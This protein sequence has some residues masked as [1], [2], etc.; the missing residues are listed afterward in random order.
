MSGLTFLG[1]STDGFVATET[2]G[3]FSNANNLNTFDEMYKDV[4]TEYCAKD[5]N[6]MQDINT[7][8]KKKSMLAG[9][10]DRLLGELK[11]ECENMIAA[12]Q[13]DPNKEFG[14]HKTYYEMLSNMF[15]NCV[16]DFVKESTRVGNLLPIKAVDFPILIKQQLKLATKDIIQTEVTRTPIVKKHIEQTYIIDPKTNKRWKYPQAMYTDEFKEVYAAGMGLPI[17]ETAVELP[18]FDYDVVGGLTDAVP[19]NKEEFT[20][21][22]QVFAVIVGDEEI[23]LD[24]PMRINLSDNM[25]LGG[26]IDVTLA[27]GTEFKDLLSGSVDFVNKTVTLSSAKGEDGVTAVKFRG[28]LNN[29][30]NR[31]TVTFDYQREEREWKIDDG[32]K[33][34]AQYTL[35]QLEDHKAL[36]DIDLY[37]KS[38]NNLTELMVQMEDNNILEYLD[39]EFEKYKGVELTKEQ[40]LGW[41]S[42]VAE[43]VFDC[44]STSL[45]TAL[46]SEYIQKMLKFVIDGFIIDICEAAKIENVTFVMYGNPK[47]IRLL[48]SSINWVTRPGSTVNG[49]KLDYG[50]GIMTSG[51]VK[52]QVVS[53][54]KKNAEY[55]NDEKIHKGIRLIPYFLNKEQ[56][57]FKHYKYTSHVLTSQNSAYR[58]NTNDYPGGAYTYVVGT[59]RYKTIAVQAIEAEVDFANLEPYV[60]PSYN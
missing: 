13:A 37:Q 48:D 35:E 29:E 49:V 47:Y 6:L 18:L 44:D 10:K 25:W 60:R 3:G 28:H 20:F 45:T 54:M 34:E 27:D 58:P 4:Y 51:N 52:V 32:M 43:R 11:T 1:E 17:K 46:P 21:D 5:I 2:V 15:D 24:Q 42:F 55:D 26:K 56:M 22:L 38:Y 59:S 41:S 19:A 53:T 33:I 7:L 14:T 36:L 30:K 12:E 23:V 16:D 8:I 40:L 9:L 50:Y 57:T 31:R 39:N